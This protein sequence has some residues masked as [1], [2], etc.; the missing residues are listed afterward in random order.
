VA[1]TREERH[2]LYNGQQRSEQSARL[3]AQQMETTSAYIGADQREVAAVPW[4]WRGPDRPAD[5]YFHAL[6]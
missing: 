2:D 6:V 1:E 4:V 5:S 3:P